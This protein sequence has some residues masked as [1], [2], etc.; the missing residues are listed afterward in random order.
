MNLFI[1]IGIVLHPSY[2]VSQVQTFK[3]GLHNQYKRVTVVNHKDA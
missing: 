3:A 2:K 1:I